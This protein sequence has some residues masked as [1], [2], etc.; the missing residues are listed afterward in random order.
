M[1]GEQGLKLSPLDLGLSEVFVG[2]A[3]TLDYELRRI[4]DK[5]LG[6]FHASGELE[7]ECSRCL[8]HFEESV[9]AD[10]V[11]EF[12]AM[13]EKKDPRKGLDPDAPELGV[14]FFEGD[15]LPLGEEIRQEMELQVPLAPVCKNECK[16]LCP[17]CGCNRNETDCG[18]AA[19]EKDSP[20]SGLKTLFK[21]AKEN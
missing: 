16:G 18:C 6:K 2:P 12:E 11:A 1:F 19:L 10:F 20:F 9:S 4:Q 15:H 7:L 17:V 5:V 3:L 13:P 8:R 21:K 14:V